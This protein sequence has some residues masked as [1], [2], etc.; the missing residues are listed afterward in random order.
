MQKLSSRHT[1]FYKY[2][3]ILT[4][5]LGFAAG[6][7]EVLFIDPQFD[8]RWIQYALAWLLITLFIFFATGS[9]KTVTLNREKKQLTVS[10]YLKSEIIDC[11]DVIA[12]D[13]SSLLSPKLVWITLKKSTTFGNKISFLP[14]HRPAR[15]IGKHPLVMELREEFNVTG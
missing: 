5:I 9:I 14:A 2:I 6:T 8:A 4:W 12:V 1:F 3:F 11:D 15:S 7:R 13:G 10:N